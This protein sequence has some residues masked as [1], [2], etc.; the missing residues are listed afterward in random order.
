MKQALEIIFSQ[1][2]LFIWQI[3]FATFK[4]KIIKTLENE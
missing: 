4:N 2:E 3:L 1:R